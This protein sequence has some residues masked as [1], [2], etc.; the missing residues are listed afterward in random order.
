[1]SLIPDIY[2]YQISFYNNDFKTDHVFWLED[3]PDRVDYFN[4]LRDQIIQLSLRNFKQAFFFQI[5]LKTLDPI[6]MKDEFHKVTRFNVKD[7][8]Y[9]TE[10]SRTILYIYLDKIFTRITNIPYRIEVYNHNEDFY[11]YYSFDFF[12]DDDKTIKKLKETIKKYIREFTTKKEKKMSSLEVKFK[13]N[14]NPII[15]D[16][17]VQ[18]IKKGDVLTVDYYD[19]LYLVLGKKEER[20]TY[21]NYAIKKNEIRLSNHTEAYGMDMLELIDEF[22]KFFGIREFNRFITK[23]FIKTDDKKLEHQIR[24]I[25]NLRTI[26]KDE[27][28]EYVDRNFVDLEKKPKK[29]SYDRINFMNDLHPSSVV[30]LEKIEEI[31]YSTFVS[32]KEGEMLEERLLEIDKKYY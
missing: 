10:G 14:G 5:F 20:T 17:H 16:H 19:K 13:K 7:D 23:R 3:K 24:Y 30:F 8:F 32:P 22:K 4:D 11:D 9:R 15:T 1:M 29:K 25:I 27:E 31:D 6:K 2:P 26:H 21:E 28:G 12:Y 18:K